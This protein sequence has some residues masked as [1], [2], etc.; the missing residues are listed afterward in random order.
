MSE[1]YLVPVYSS[2]ALSDAEAIMDAVLEARMAENLLPLT[3][4][5]L[6]SGGGL[7]VLKREDGSGLLRSDIALGN[8]YGALGMGI[9][10]RTIRDRLGD[11]PAFQNA[12]AAASEGKFIPVPG[13]VLILKE[14][15]QCI[16]AVGSSGDASDRDEYAV[17]TGIHAAGFKTHPEAP[18]ENWRHA[19]L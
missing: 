3:V 14:T 1:Y 2:L 13:G 19:K 7:V 9:S 17:I 6:D 15:G 10:S 16:G 8:A 18:A 4:A 11:R 5:I 12:I